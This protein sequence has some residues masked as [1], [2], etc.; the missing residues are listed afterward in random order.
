MIVDLGPLDQ[1]QGESL[2]IA[3]DGAIWLSTEAAKKSD[4]PSLGRLQCTLSDA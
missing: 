1:P 3:N 2:A 4:R